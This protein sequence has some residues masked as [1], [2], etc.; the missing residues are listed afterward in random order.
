MDG[1]EG[2]AR[3]VDEAHRGWVIRLV[4]AIDA[5][6]PG[7]LG[8]GGRVA[9]LEEATQPDEVAVGGRA[10]GEVALGQVAL[11]V[12]WQEQEAAALSVV[13]P[14]ET[15]VGDVVEPVVVD[16]TEHACRRLD[17]DR[18]RAQ[19]QPADRVHVLGVR[20]QV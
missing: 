9:L 16:E 4:E 3:A 13:R 11:V 12:R 19:V 20:G 1:V 5:R 10:V 17:H 14:R 6:P 18:P 7:G 15:D 8:G 2:H